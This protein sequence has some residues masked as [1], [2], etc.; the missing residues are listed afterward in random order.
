M[1]KLIEKVRINR[2]QREEL[3]KIVRGQK[4]EK[5]MDLR[6]SII[7]I[8]AQG[9]HEGEVAKQL[10]ITIK[11]VRKWRDRFVANGIDGLYDLP[12][13]GAPVKFTVVQ[14][15]EVIAIACD[16]PKNYGYDPCNYWTNDLL[17]DAANNNI[18]DLNISRSSVVRTL[19]MNQ[20]KPHKFRMWLHS[21]D[22]EFKEKANEIVDLYLNPPENAA[23]LSIDE[24]TGM[25]ATER[26][27]ETV[28][29]KCG[30]A[31]KYEHE[32]I[33]H[34]TQSLIASFDIKT[35]N[36]IAECGDSRKATDLVAFMERVAEEYKN[37]KTIHVI[38]DNLN[39]HKDGAD[40]RWTEFNK[41]YE[42]KFKFHYTPK[43]A[44]WV[45]QIEIFFSI[46]YKR[47]LKFASFTSKEALRDKILK[48]IKH[49][50]E[51]D[52][53]PF[54]WAFKG[55]PMQSVVK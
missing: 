20:L 28:M 12:R 5:R 50:N 15:C 35:G 48:S 16:Y 41:K 10:E 39:I 7:L 26:K 2:K 32:Y 8:L 45:N 30:E 52:R 4:T 9:N 46:V 54:H 29:P 37:E 44:S 49:W 25:Q 3:D 55:Y 31:G 17:T 14:R 51:K 22:P 1:R 13:S 27:N 33:R 19:N 40:D 43:H 53:H 24:K 21:K 34:G 18:E 47:C 23:V 38:W 6:A 36:V 42:G 11:T